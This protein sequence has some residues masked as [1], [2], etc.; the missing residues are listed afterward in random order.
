MEKDPTQPW[1]PFPAK[2]EETRGGEGGR[3]PRIRE[4]SRGK[5]GNEIGREDRTGAI[6]E[7]EAS[8]G[9]DPCSAW[10]WGDYRNEVGLGAMPAE[11]RGRPLGR[12]ARLH[13]PSS[14]R[15]RLGSDHVG[16]RP[17]PVP[18]AQSNWLHWDWSQA[19]WI[20]SLPTKARWWR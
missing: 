7:E 15:D 13:S 10:D 5:G 2:R 14:S 19:K 12:V 11:E 9:T 1:S 4:E 3:P 8:T 6:V 16:R 18:R 17:R 20:L